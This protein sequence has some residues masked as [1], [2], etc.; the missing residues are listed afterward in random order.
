M[1]QVA[2]DTLQTKLVLLF[3]YTIFLFSCTESISIQESELINGKT[4]QQFVRYN[5]YN[6]TIKIYYPDNQLE[7]VRKYSDGK[8]YGIHEG[9][10]INGNQ[11]YKYRFKNDQSIGQHMQWHSNG[12]L[13]I[14]KNF[15]NGI[16]NGEQKAWDQNGDLMYKYIY[17]DG[18]KYGI[19]GS[20]V[21]N[22]M[23]ELAEQN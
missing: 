1:Q 16:E 7:S 3:L 22:G 8:K 2:V 11:K 12:Q 21:C 4:V 14:V 23:N 15:K 19:Q 18:R 9:W 6:G 5:Q 13:F 17:Y 20:I 10:W